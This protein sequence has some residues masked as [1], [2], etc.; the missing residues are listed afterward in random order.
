MH[1]PAP[2]NRRSL[3]AWPLSRLILALDDV[4]RTVGPDSDT[5]RVLARVL[6]ERLRGER[7]QGRSEEASDVR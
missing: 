3:S 2:T 5:A 7:P 6:R 4:E 1:E